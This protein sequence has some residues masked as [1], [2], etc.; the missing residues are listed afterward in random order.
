MNAKDIKLG[1]TYAL[2]RS[3]VLV[4]FRV[5]T[6]ITKRDGEGTKNYAEGYIAEDRKDDTAPK[7]ET[8]KVATLEGQYEKVA[9]LVEKAKR[10][11]SERKRQAA[12]HLA[13]QERVRELLYKVTGLPKPKDPAQYQQAFKLDYSGIDIGKQALKPLAEVLAKLCQ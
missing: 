12:E 11:E 5:I 10:E 13:L 8:V 3:D 7:L 2:R 9:E 4:R 1:D 6:I